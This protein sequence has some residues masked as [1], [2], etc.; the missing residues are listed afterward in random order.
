MEFENWSFD[1]MSYVEPAREI[2]HVFGNHPVGKLVT[3]LIAL[4]LIVTLLNGAVKRFFKKTSFIEERKEKT[5]ISMVSSVLNFTAIAFFL[6]YVLN[7]FVDDLS[8]LLAGAGVIGIVLGFG[9]QSLIKDLLSGLFFLY[10][11]QLHQGDFVKI[12]NQ[13][14]GTV[15][16]IGFRVLKI[17]EW[18]GKLLTISN[19]N[20]KEVQNYNMEKM[21]VI[22][23]V[24]TSF[25]Q[26]P[27]DVYEALETAC[28]I[29]NETL[30]GTLLK[31]SL[32]EVVEP[33]QIYGMT[34]LNESQ[35]GYQYT[36]VGL[37]EDQHYWQASNETR[38]VIAQEMYIN[39]I[40][41]AEEIKYYRTTLPEKRK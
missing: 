39:N 27:N 28:A 35:H 17:R 9:A 19:G 22:E 11:K 40:K 18:S 36:V 25:Y 13:Y 34:S 24:T 4:W 30:E 21:R 38:K 2:L 10:E 33:F 1:L 16:E 41:M 12:N 31:N 15:E 32:G 20:I 14:T 8:S 26:N 6:F 5:I 23:K 7:L 3:A 37:V 29:L